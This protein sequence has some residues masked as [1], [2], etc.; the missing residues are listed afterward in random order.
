MNRWLVLFF[1]LIYIL[2]TLYFKI[3]NPVSSL[4][5]LRYDRLNI[6]SVQKRAT[7]CLAS[8][9]LTLLLNINKQNT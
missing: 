8:H 6:G 2:Q 9:N 4:Y 3:K 1:T 7:L 5:F